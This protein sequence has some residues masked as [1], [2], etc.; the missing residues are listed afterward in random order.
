MTQ[1][2]PFFKEEFI[3][4]KRILFFFWNPSL[5]SKVT[6]ILVTRPLTFWNCPPRIANHV[7]KCCWSWCAQMVRQLFVGPTPMIS[8]GKCSACKNHF[9]RCC[10]LQIIKQ[11]KTEI[12]KI[13]RR[14]VLGGKSAS[15][16]EK[17]CNYQTDAYNFCN[18]S[19]KLIYFQ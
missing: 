8:N 6:I 7:I 15:E 5:N 9:I 17:L 10:C 19:W 14:C 13:Q 2:A 12:W 18:T 4:F 16:P 1:I 11:R 3:T